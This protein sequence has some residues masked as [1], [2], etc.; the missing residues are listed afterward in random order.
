LF[1]KL[2]LIL[3]DLG[4]FFLLVKFTGKTFLGALFFLN[5]FPIYLSSVWGIY[6]SLMLFPLMLG[7]WLLT[8]WTSTTSASVSFAVAGLAKL[9]GF[10][11]YAC[12]VCGALFQ[13]RFRE[14]L[15]QAV[16]GIA[17]IAGVLVPT[18]LAG[19]YRVFVYGI[20][21]RFV[22]LGLKSAGGARYNLFEVILGIN[23]S[24]VL[25]TI[26]I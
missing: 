23:P 24:A 19:G 3:C 15:L 6:D 1:L 2:P 9:F 5:P 26:P 12:M 20:F 21:N 7:L 17:V 8:R 18:F 4:I 10:L 11:P 22:G 13:R 25:P 16:G 14:F